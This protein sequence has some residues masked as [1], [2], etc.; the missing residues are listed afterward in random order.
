MNITITIANNIFHTISVTKSKRKIYER[1]FISKPVY[2]WN[3]ILFVCFP[4]DYKMVVFKYNINKFKLSC[5][6]RIN[7]YSVVVCPGFS[8][9][10]TREAL[11]GEDFIDNNIVITAVKK[12]TV[13]QVLTFTTEVLRLLFITTKRE[14]LSVAID[15]RQSK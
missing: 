7:S 10:D 11:R 12:W 6:L 13:W 9:T 4:T 14:M 2:L 1:S 5:R 8:V 3:A 15:N